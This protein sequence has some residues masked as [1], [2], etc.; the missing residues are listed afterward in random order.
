MRG[1]WDAWKNEKDKRNLSP[2]LEC[3]VATIRWS[4]WKERNKRVFQFE[5]ISIEKPRRAF[6]KLVAIIFLLFLLFFI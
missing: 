5:A 3:L 6:G 1:L 2:H 4:L